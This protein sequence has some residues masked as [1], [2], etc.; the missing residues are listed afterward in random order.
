MGKGQAQSGLG[1]LFVDIGL[2][3][4]GE[5]LKGLNSVSASF[6]LTKNAAMQLTKPLIDLGKNTIDNAVKFNQMNAVLG[7]SLEKAQQL[8]TYLNKYNVGEGLLG[9]L[10]DIMDHLN[11]VNM[12]LEG[13]DGAFVTAMT[14]L[15][16][17]WRKYRGGTF[18][19]MLNMVNDV[20]E[21]VKDM[22]L[23]QARVYMKDLKLPVDLLYA[24]KQGGFNLSEAVT[25]TDESIKKA[26]EFNEQLKLLNQNINAKLQSGMGETLNLLTPTITDI[27]EAMNPDEVISDKAKTRLKLK[28]VKGAAWLANPAGHIENTIWENIKGIYKGKETGPAAPIDMIDTN[29]ILR[30]IPNQEA[31]IP[32]NKGNISINVTNQNDIYG[33]NADEIADKLA[34]ITSEDIENAKNNAYQISN[35]TGI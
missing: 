19:D 9:N 27:N 34:G 2:N 32:I 13:I 11:R 12:G 15:G 28:G 8:T 31:P 16:L 5:A 22:D 24:F 14:R 7:I 21:K 30:N 23:G 18:E 10:G 26:T 6:L 29:E 17:D 4:V 20:Q 25:R 1:Y 35:I 3:G 33:N